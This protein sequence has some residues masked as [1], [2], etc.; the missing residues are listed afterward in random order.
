MESRALWALE[1][2]TRKPILLICDSLGRLHVVPT[3]S[4]TVLLDEASAVHIV[5]EDGN[6]ITALNPFNVLLDPTS[7]VHILDAAGNEIT[8]LNPFNVD[9]SDRAARL[10]G[11]VD[12][13]DRGARNLGQVT[14]LD[15]PNLDAFG[16]LRTSNQETLF[17]SQLQYN[18]S[19]LLWESILTAGGTVTHLPNE[20]SAR[21]RVTA[22]SGD[23]VVR[24]TIPYWRYQ[25]GKSMFI[26]MTSVMGA[27]KANVRQ[28]VGFFDAENGLF[29]EQ[30]GTN[31][32]VVRRTFVTGVAVDTAVDQADWNLDTLDGLG[33]S[34]VTIDTTRDQIFCIDLQWL[35]TGRVRM[36]FF[37]GGQLIYCHEFLGANVRTEV[38]MTTANLPLRY[39]LEN[40]G[41]SASQ[42]DMIQICNAITSEGGYNPLGFNFGVSNGV[43]TIG[44]TT[45]RPI[46]S[47]RLALLN[48]AIEN[49]GQ[50]I[51]E[52][53]SVIAKSNDAFVEIVLNGALT[54]DAFAAVGGNSMAERDVAA[55]AIAGGDV[56][57][58]DFVS[59]AGSGSN[60]VGKAGESLLSK[61]PLTLDVPGTTS[62][63][64]SIVV[65]SFNATSTVSGAFN[66][67]ELY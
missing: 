37:F 26:T 60:A 36:G 44:V 2:N 31:L 67:R 17:D 16:R 8:A 12:V 6:E 24:Q 56:I 3:T 50:I 15:S 13:S 49:R 64:L 59:A 34:G 46:L 23:A 21:M 39:E 58:S 42:T 11:I 53:F 62:A 55:D 30:D 63:I 7:S 47:L 29:F 28:R 54:N 52:S 18:L 38:Y 5:D 14:Y 22:T 41:A 32:R 51:P 40:T 19:P 4:V 33:P 25:P 48:N 66:W 65:T 43:T 57:H 45:R 20:S 9:L 27:I 1:E 35:G 61:I 10:V